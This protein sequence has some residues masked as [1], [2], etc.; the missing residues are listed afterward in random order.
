MTRIEKLL[1]FATIFEAP[2][3]DPESGT[4]LPL[5]ELSIAAAEALRFYAA[6]LQRNESYE[7]AGPLQSRM[8]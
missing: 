8:R 1:T 4:K 3:Y 2:R 6:W 5:S 7:Q